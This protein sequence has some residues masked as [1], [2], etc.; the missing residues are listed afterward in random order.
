M[1]VSKELYIERMQQRN[2]ENLASV[3]GITYNELL[4]TE[5]EVLR[6]ESNDGVIYN[7]IISFSNNTPKHILD[8]IIGIDN[9]NQVWLTP[10]EYYDDNNF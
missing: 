1:G 9:N 8:K 10:Y 5:Y 6:N 4:Q 3:L 2:N 7:D